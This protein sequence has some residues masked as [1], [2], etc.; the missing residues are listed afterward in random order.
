METSGNQQ[1]RE[2][3]RK[4]EAYRKLFL[5]LWL[6]HWPISLL[7]FL[8]VGGMCAGA[9]AVKSYR[10]NERFVAQSKMFFYP[11]QSLKFRTVDIRQA[12]ELFS[13]QT[14]LRQAQDRLGVAGG[15][16]TQSEIAVEKNKPNLIIVTVAAGREDT[17]VNLVNSLTTVCMEE[18]ATFRNRDLSSQ[19]TTLLDRKKELEKAILACERKQQEMAAVSGALT[20]YQELERLRKVVSDELALLSDTNVQYANEDAKRKKLEEQLKDTSRKGL[21]YATQLQAFLNDQERLERE[22]MRLQQLYTDLNPKIRI[23]VSE[24]EH[25][26]KSYREFLE[27]NDISDFS[28]E[29]LAMWDELEKALR[30]TLEKLEFLYEN[31]EALN[32]EV[33]RHQKAVAELTELM[34]AYNEAGIQRA[35]LVEILHATEEAISELQLLVAAVPNDITLVERAADAESQPLFTKKSAALCVVLALWATGLA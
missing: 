28:P 25:S 7:V 8:L 31:R 32:A 9:V 23:V 2:Q 33:A 34:P 14:V 17:A 35:S 4:L 26:R 15:L 20:P 13:R 30:A 16:P 3:L 21:Q 19:M 6:K 11:R 24:L 12:Q 29:N 1:E 18:Y 10:S 5:R 27:K 22:V